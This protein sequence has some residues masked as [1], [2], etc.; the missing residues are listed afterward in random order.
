MTN[1]I[2][3]YEDYL[4]HIKHASQNTIASYMRDVHQYV[5][6]LNTI[7]QK[8]LLAV[9]RKIIGDYT[10]WLTKQ[11]KSPATI[12]RSLASLKSFYNFLISLGVIGQNPVHNIQVE[13]S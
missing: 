11:G 12:S 8:D 4:I 6:Y 10:H 9:D 3:E 1:V 7:M 2:N 5:S 13:K